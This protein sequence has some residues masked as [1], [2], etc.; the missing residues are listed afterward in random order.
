ML[1]SQIPNHRLAL[2]PSALSVE[3]LLRCQL[4]VL[5]GKRVLPSRT[6]TDA[7]L[8]RGSSLADAAVTRT[9]RFAPYKSSCFLLFL[10]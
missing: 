4:G 3:P 1:P 2:L 8:S 6:R 9:R 5:N 10:S 7:L